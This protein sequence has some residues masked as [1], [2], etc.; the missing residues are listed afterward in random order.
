MKNENFDKNSFGAIGIGAMIV[1]IA[2]I[3]VAAVASAV[4]IQTAEKLQQNAQT[5]GE[6][7]R[8]EIGGKIQ[9]HG[10]YYGDAGEGF[11]L[12]FSLA[13][14]SDT[15]L[16]TSVNW[17]LFCMYDNTGSTFGQD[18][19][20]FDSEAISLLSVHD[21]NGGVAGGEGQ[22]SD[23]TD[24]DSLATGTKYVIPL[25]DT[26]ATIADCDPAQVNTDWS[27]NG[28]SGKIEMYIHVTGGGTTYETLDASGSL[29]EGDSLL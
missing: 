12:V 26:A 14:G 15:V 17:Q 27:D 20:T 23:A 25:G 5:T 2:L 1:F 3:L 18:A 4:I 11:D 21:T 22:F 19:G 13:P 7:T 9:I 8:E 28:G 16:D 24:D 29:N 6:D 10:A